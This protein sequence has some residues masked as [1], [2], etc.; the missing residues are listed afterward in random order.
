LRVLRPPPTR[1]IDARSPN[2]PCC[3]SPPAR[4]TAGPQG[5]R[6]PDGGL[7]ARRRRGRG[8]LGLRHRVRD[9]YS[10]LTVADVHLDRLHDDQLDLDQLEPDLVVDQLEPQLVVNQLHDSYVNDELGLGH[11]G[12]DVKGAR[13]AFARWRALGALV[14][15]GTTDPGRLEAAV[16]IATA[17]LDACDLA[18]SRFRADSELSR[19]NERRDRRDVAASGWLV[20]AVSVARH[21]AQ[22]TD[23]L[24]DPTLG[25]Q[26]IALGYDRSFEQLDPDG[27]PVSF[28]A[29]KVGAWQAIKSDHRR[30]RVS[31]PS[32]VTLD[33]GATAKALCSDRAAARTELATGAGTLVSIGGDLAVAGTAPAEGWCIRVTDKADTPPDSP[34]PG[35]TVSI[36]QGAIA[37][38]GVSARSWRREGQTL[39]HLIDPRTGRPAGGPWRTVSVAAPTCIEANTAS[40]A[41]V[42]LGAAA[43]SWLEAR[44]LSARLV[45]HGGGVLTTG[46]W[47]T[48]EAGPEPGASTGTRAA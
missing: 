23:G 12:G 24:V 20:D 18:C 46:G 41:A 27:D 8:R 28:Q 35:Q 21:A 22:E 13:P 44:G 19:L 9:R 31:I 26:L 4:P 16:E 7:P 29:V 37:T 1:T 10:H 38:S 11:V 33:L 15:V 39:H 6:R 48:D 14:V 17:E 45:D 36:D 42:L 34:A 25:A 40:T 47:P 3:P 5:H 2:A 30:R 32:G 43:P